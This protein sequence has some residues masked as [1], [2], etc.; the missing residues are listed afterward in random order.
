MGNN[1][2][3]VLRVIEPSDKQYFLKV[4][5]SDKFE[6]VNIYDPRYIPIY[7]SGKINSRGIFE[8]PIHMAIAVNGVIRTVTRTSEFDSAIQYFEA[9]LPEDALINGKNQIVF[10]PLLSHLIPYSD[11][12]NGR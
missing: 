5:K 3:D 11:R 10:Y 2:E 9:I 1:I 8:E 12:S 7:I 4:S 6:D